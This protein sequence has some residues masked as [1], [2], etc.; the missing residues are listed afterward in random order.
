MTIHLALKHFRSL[1]HGVSR[2]RTLL[3]LLFASLDHPATR[4]SR[5]SRRDYLP[6]RSSTVDLI[7]SLFFHPSEHAWRRHGRSRRGSGF[8]GSA[9]TRRK[10]LRFGPLAK[11]PHTRTRLPPF[12]SSSFR[13]LTLE[14]TYAV[15]LAE[16]GNE[17]S[18]A[19]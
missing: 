11:R 5:R 18:S 16:K 6:D 13:F 9:S 15:A 1:W 10:H 3:S 2:D 17:I 4:D 19:N 7:V 14:R 12:A 8:T